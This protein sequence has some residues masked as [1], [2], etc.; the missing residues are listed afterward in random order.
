MRWLR[1]LVA[2]VVLAVVVA[3]PPIALVCFTGAP[4]TMSMPDLRAAWSALGQGRVE[5]DVVIGVLALVLW[6]AW[7]RLV[8]SLA[9]E[10]WHVVRRCPTPP[11][12]VLGRGSQRLAALLVSGIW[13]LATTAGRAPASAADATGIPEVLVRLLPGGPV[14]PDPLDTDLLD[15][16][17]PDPGP[18][19][20]APG[21]AL[22]TAARPTWSV[23]Q[24]DSWWGL[25]ERLYGDGSRWRELYELNL[26]RDAAPGARVG[27]TTEFV[28]PGW[29]VVLPEVPTVE[30]VPG[31]TLSAIARDRLGD[32]G[33]WPEIW[34]ANRDAEFDGR[35]FDD[36]NL[37]LPGWELELPVG[38]VLIETSVAVPEMPRAGVGVEVAVEVPADLPAASAADPVARPRPE[39]AARAVVLSGPSVSAS[40]A[41]QTTPADDVCPAPLPAPGSRMPRG[42]G[43]AVLLAT[44]AVAA[45]EAA[46][47]RRW[48]S[49]PPHSRL[50]EPS[51]AAA[52]AEERTRLADQSE[53]VV[54]LDLVLRAAA[55]VVAAQDHTTGVAPRVQ[56][57]VA[58][59]TGTIELRFDAAS[60]LPSPW[61]PSGDRW[62]RLPAGIELAELAV[63]GRSTAVPCPALV[64][65]GRAPQGEVFVDVEAMGV[66]AVEGDAHDTGAVVRAVGLGLALSP[67]SL[68]ATLI[69]VKGEAESW[70]AGRSWQLVDDAAEAVELAVACVSGM[71]ERLD[72]V[73]T[74]FLAR[75]AGGLEAWEPAIVVL[76]R[77]D[78][79]EEHRA[80]LHQLACSPAVGIAVV[81]DTP[82]VPG[83]ACL[84]PADKGWLLEP[85]GLEL[86][87]VGL[88]RH[89]ALAVR[90]MLDEAQ[91][92]P[93][94][95][96]PAAVELVPVPEWT[97]MVRVLGPLDVVDAAGEAAR[98]ER[99]KAA[100][101][102]AWLA[103]HRER[104][105]RSAARTALWEVDVRDATFANVVSDARRSLAR[106]APPPP[107]EDWIG[108][109]FTD[110]L[111]LHPA[112]VTDVD[113]LRAHVLRA[114]LLDGSAGVDELR[115]GLAL[116]RDIV[117]SGTGFVWPDSS[118]LTSEVVLLVV[119]AAT[120]MA[121][122]C[123]EL[124]DVDGVFWA[125]RQGLV[126]LPGHEELVGLRM[127][128]YAATGDLAGV[129]SVWEEYLRSLAG[130]AWGDSPSPKLVRL[131]QQLL[132]CTDRGSIP[133][134]VG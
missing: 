8:G 125:T 131:R 119:G 86:S 58:A 95:L 50:P 105:T 6:I 118:G 85:F 127:Q 2:L 94:V 129:R 124:G 132:S 116:V 69:G 120:E 33:A 29:T 134:S 31:D 28:E 130:D 70:Q 122:R 34:E 67:F 43:G 49:L 48:R 40:D 104:A 35:R 15:P 113:V 73:T 121:S 101:L 76:S 110:Q 20:A 126:V 21:P 13:V 9:V 78:V 89:E 61:E 38:E 53:L 44:G 23:R 68:S 24:H 18:T 97:L 37:I 79:A 80:V 123:L 54:R 100:E 11:V 17:L 102:V 52:H 84:R 45:L 22:G 64:H 27:P 92:A 51:P 87:P 117:F 99:S 74:T 112:V 82:G 3:A 62:W 83:G 91:H 81:T 115:A 128:A 93:P 75:A 32:A 114:R 42:L 96:E 1:R 56:L 90:S 55:A 108:R 98:F 36:P 30:V 71:R 72:E 65:V 133:R 66:L 63:L 77:D 111:P 60:K 7:V 25:A 12:R 109:T 59:A 47:R 4:W 14:E 10:F 46:R 107:G 106:L 41:P 103:L 57:A 19:S 16:D 39:P 26:G 5:A 88:D